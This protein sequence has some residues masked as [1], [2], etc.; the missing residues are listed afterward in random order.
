MSDQNHEPIS[1]LFGPGPSV[2]EFTPGQEV[3]V[4]MGSDAGRRAVIVR[5]LTDTSIPG[6]R[7]RF[8]DGRPSRVAA[9]LGTSAR[10]GPEADVSA[11][12]LRKI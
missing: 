12:A 5:Q 4:V 9:L 11:V 3:L 6:L 10:P 8:A 1:L 7:I 2:A